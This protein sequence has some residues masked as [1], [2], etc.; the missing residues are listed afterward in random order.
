M[1]VGFAMLLAFRDRGSLRL[2][3][4]LLP[5]ILV[6]LLG[7]AA[8]SGIGERRSGGMES[9][10]LDESAQGRLDA[11]LAGGRMVMRHPVLGVGFGRFADNFESYASNA[12]IW[13]K[14]ETHNSYIKVAAE[15]GFAGLL[16]FMALVF[17]SARTGYRVRALERGDAGLVRAARKS[18][19]PTV[20]GFC[21]TAFFLSQCWSWFFY[22]IFAQAASMEELFTAGSGDDKQ[23]S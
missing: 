10:G 8:V 13:G 7:V 18:L 3:L 12:V 9:E 5:V 19:L 4:A 21:L 22:I 16:P 6:A 17:L 1:G 14:H 15:T 23:S 2:K 11:W 20:A